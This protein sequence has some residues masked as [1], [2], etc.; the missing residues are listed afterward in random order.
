[1]ARAL[2]GL[3]YFLLKLPACAGEPAG[4]DLTLLV[5]KLHKKIRVLVID[6]TDT[7]LLKAAV[8]RFDLCALDGFIH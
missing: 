6:V 3:R 8:F 1:M 4:K 2:Y 5:D 7:V